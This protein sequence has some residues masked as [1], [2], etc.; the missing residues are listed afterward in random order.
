V[1]KDT[2]FKPGQSGN[3]ET[4]FKPG[5]QHRWPPRQSGNPAGIAR[6]RLQF[7][8]SFYAALLDRGSAE[9]VAS[10]LWESAR[11]REPWAIQAVLQ[12][13]APEF[14]QAG[15]QLSKEPA[16]EGGPGRQPGC[17]HY[18]SGHLNRQITVKTALLTLLLMGYS[19][20]AQDP[21]FQA[22][23]PSGSPDGTHVGPDTNT[24]QILQQALREA[25]AGR[26][27]PAAPAT[28]VNAV[29]PA[30]GR[31]SP[32][33]RN[34]PR[35]LPE[36]KPNGP[37][38]PSFPAASTAPI[39]APPGVVLPVNPVKAVL[40]VPAATHSPLEEPLPQGMIDRC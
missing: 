40:P 31:D 30:A 29:K 4:R 3:P 25:L 18:E 9:E 28:V 20:W 17:G 6:S 8:E 23:P 24:D 39:V 12:R 14:K 5:N 33:L 1:K 36:A 2:K 38:I 35:A 37:V 26:T 11:K 34:T 16:Q 10:L 19:L 13:L 15:S 7:E 22:L 32:V 21:A 27:N